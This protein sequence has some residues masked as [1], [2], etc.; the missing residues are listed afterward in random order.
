MLWLTFTQT[1][2][3]AQPASPSPP[4]QE[5]PTGESPSAPKT[6]DVQP[7]GLD[8]QIAARL[9]T[10]AQ[11]TQWF[12]SPQVHV[13]EGVVFLDGRTSR[14]ED[15]DWAGELARRTQSVV[16]V[17][18]RIT[19]TERSI[20]DLAPA[21][22]ELRTL[23]T[24][25]V[26]ASPFIGF[27]LMVLIIAGFAARFTSRLARRLLSR[28]IANPLLREVTT[29]ALSILV[30]LFGLY[31]VLRVSGLTRPALTVLGALALPD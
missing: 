22:D 15:R 21:L 8:E 16:T 10:I 25:A 12:E 5:R 20:L 28:R 1:P 27:G 17:V 26:Q 31:L 14:L 11:A 2:I 6:V 19:L 30:F 24:H 9:Q 18:N 13:K 3:L 7:E 4:A 23:A 29:K